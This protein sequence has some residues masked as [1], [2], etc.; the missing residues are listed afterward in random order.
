M[1]PVQV[2][3]FH[4]L[5]STILSHSTHFPTVLPCQR[6]PQ[7]ARLE[8]HTVHFLS[9]AIILDSALPVLLSMNLPTGLQRREIHTNLSLIPVIILVS[10]RHLPQSTN[11]TIGPSLVLEAYAICSHRL[12]VQTPSE[13]S[14]PRPPLHH[15]QT[16]LAATW[17]SAVCLFQ[18]AHKHVLR[19]VP[20]HALFSL[21]GG[22]C[23]SK[24]ASSH[25]ISRNPSDHSPTT[26]N[27]W[28]GP[29]RSHSTA[30]SPPT[31]PAKRSAASTQPPSSTIQTRLSGLESPPSPSPRPSASSI[32]PANP[33]SALAP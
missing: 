11:L 28:N 25:S 21:L 22:R 14:P 17:A 1:C 5:L 19:R 33:S 32:R 3:G 24:P 23:S 9:P 13:T 15:G 7:S 26:K 18:I 20:R 6:H 4:I 29:L 31:S 12:Q 10:P 27:R 8:V 16:R 30:H 2:R